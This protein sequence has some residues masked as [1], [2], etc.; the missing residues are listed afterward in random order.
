MALNE[1]LVGV[2]MFFRKKPLKKDALI[3]F[4]KREHDTG[5]IFININNDL[6]NAVENGADTWPPL[7]L[8]AYA[9]ARRAAVAALYIQGVVEEELYDHVKTFFKGM[10]I[11]T[12]HTVEFQENAFDAAIDYMKIYSPV[13]TKLSIRK[14]IQIAEEYEIPPGQMSDSELFESVIEM[15]HSEQSACSE[16]SHTEKPEVTSPFEPKPELQ[17]EQGV[18]SYLAKISNF[19]RQTLCVE[20][21]N[22]RAA[23]HNLISMPSGLNDFQEVQTL[24]TDLTDKSVAICMFVFG[25]PTVFGYGGGD[26]SSFN[27]LVNKID[28]SVASLNLE[29]EQHGH[30]LL[31]RLGE[32]LQEI[33]N[34]DD[35]P[36]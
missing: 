1:I 7:M 3:N 28:D 12:G 21:A 15:A 22:V 31:K 33:N 13:I 26:L 16:K 6:G 25:Q 29:P 4:V 18:L 10:Q 32:H 8:M 23:K 35:I 5:F 17:S 11:K 9:Y 2:K 27:E 30:Q 34:D 19:D 36:F 24:V 14:I 20:F